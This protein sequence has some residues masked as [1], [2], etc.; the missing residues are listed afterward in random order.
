MTGSGTELSNEVPQENYLAF[1]RAVCWKI[2]I[3]KQYPA[4]HSCSS[5]FRIRAVWE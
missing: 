4:V 5:A 2:Q 1:S 3:V